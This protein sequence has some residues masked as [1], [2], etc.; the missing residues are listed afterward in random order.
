MNFVYICIFNLYTSISYKYTHIVTNQISDS[1]EL[2]MYVYINICISAYLHADTAV[3]RSQT[4]LFAN[5]P[6]CD[7]LET[8]GDTYAVP[9]V[10][11]VLATSY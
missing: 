9:F 1:R 7:L 6:Q 11:T 4:H 10:G 5:I 8:Y 3:S 2:N